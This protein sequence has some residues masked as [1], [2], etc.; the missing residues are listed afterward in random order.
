MAE[1]IGKKIKVEY[2][3][4]IGWRRPVKLKIGAEEHAVTKVISR[5]EEHI[6]KDAWWQR[7]HRVHYAVVL[8]DGKR[9]ELYWNRGARGEREEWVLL[10]A[11]SDADEAGR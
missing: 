5:W 9:Y 1:F 3:Q 4:E 6:L 10:K 8:D 2:R 11:L 7:K